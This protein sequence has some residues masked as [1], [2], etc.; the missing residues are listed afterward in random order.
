M[1]TRQAPAFRRQPFHGHME[2]APGFS[3]N[4]AMA[5]FPLLLARDQQTDQ[6]KPSAQGNR[7][8]RCVASPQTRAPAREHLAPAGLTLFPFSTSI[9]VEVMTP[10]IQQVLIC[11]MFYLMHY[12]YYLT[13]LSEQFY[14]I[15]TR[16]IS[17]Y[18]WKKLTHGY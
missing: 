10:N 9:V 7:P 3:S 12:T 2:F 15:G 8:F 17:F 13:Y 14:D 6:A 16:I 1:Q 5:Q 18:R 11:S 4:V